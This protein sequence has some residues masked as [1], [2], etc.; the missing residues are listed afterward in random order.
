MKLFGR[1]LAAG[2][3]AM[4]LAVGSGPS[5]VTAQEPKQVSV[6][7]AASLTSAFK[8]IGA[9]FEKE[10]PGTKVELN[11]A[12]SPTLVRQIDDGAHADVFASADEANMKKVVDAKLAVGEPQI[13]A[14]NRLAIVVEA[15]NPKKIAS[16]ADLAKPGLTIALAGPG[17]PAGEYARAAFG[18]AGVAVPQASLEVDVKAVLQKVA[19]GEADAG[20][21]YVTDVSGPKVEAVP[22]PDDVNVTASY[23]IAVLKN[24]TSPE[25]GKAFVSF[26]VSPDGQRFLS[27][28]GFLTR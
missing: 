13:F 2:S 15:G 8:A 4:L 28:A 1:V 26:V 18:K 9:A 3:L 21:V 27:E 16:L 14:K 24:G 20:I 10:H 12:G 6:F 17:V 23:P 25:L 5:T 19:L 11:V 22:I 7:A